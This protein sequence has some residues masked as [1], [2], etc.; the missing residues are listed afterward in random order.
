MGSKPKAPPAPDYVGAA[1]QQGQDN[2]AV[3]QL[4]A[5]L[6][7]PNQI[8]PWG[9]ETWQ[10]D[11]ND[12]NSWTSTISLSPEQ[13]RLLDAQNQTSLSLSSLQ[14]QGF[15]RVSDAMST[16]FSLSGVP[17]IQGAPQVQALPGANDFSADRDK[18][19]QAVMSRYNT[20]FNRQQESLNQQLLNQG[21]T[22]GSEAWMR[23]QDDLGRQR[24]DA[25]MQAILAG[26]Q[27]QSR[28]F[29]LSSR[30]NAQAFNQQLAAN[31]FGNQSRQQGIQEQA[32]LR[33][34]PLNE[35]NAL[36]TGAQV[37]APTFSTYA[38]GNA[39][40]APTFAAAQAQGQYAQQLYGQQVGDYNNQ[41]QGLFG[42]G[43]AGISAGAAFF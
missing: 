5:Q 25:E 27:E 29:D 26:G 31:Q 1:K 24:N 38:P 15:D 9:S 18:V 41:M 36:R 10:R 33:S 12:K 7:R 17:Q 6:G 8:T 30:A 22:P 14:N 39:Q 20:D 23:A 40:A 13:Q 42:L 35:L 43:A 3:A 21:L 16:P 19:Q 2:I 28:L 34:L 4:N 11:P 32:Y 37:T